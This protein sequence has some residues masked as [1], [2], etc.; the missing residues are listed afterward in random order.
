MFSSTKT[1]FKKSSTENAANSINDSNDFDNIDMKNKIDQ[2]IVLNNKENS[3]KSLIEIDLD[4]KQDIL[5]IENE[6]NSRNEEFMNLVS[7]IMMKHLHE[8]KNESIVFDF[9]FTIF[10]IT[11][12]IRK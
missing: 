3:R 9:F 7:R 11:I 12:S 6:V 10:K 8:K 2:F 5:K 1:M 4:M